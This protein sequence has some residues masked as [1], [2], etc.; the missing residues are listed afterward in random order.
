MTCSDGYFLQCWPGSGSGTPFYLSFI[1]PTDK[2]K[3]T[4]DT[5]LGGGVHE[6]QDFLLRLPTEAEVC[7]ACDV[8]SV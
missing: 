1:V 4:V 8:K 3:P 6:C 2:I 7:S 5:G